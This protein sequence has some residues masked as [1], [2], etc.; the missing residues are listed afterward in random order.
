MNFDAFVNDIKINEWNVF[1]TEVYEDGV[2]THSW[3]DT[4]EN[5]HEIYSATKVVLSIAIGIAIDEGK[6]DISRPVLDYLP[7]NKTENLSLE[8]RRIFEKITLQRLMTMSVGDFPFRAEG[9]SYIDFALNTR[10]S[11]P[12]E[13]VFNYNNISAYLAGVAL[14]EALGT[15]LGP[16]IEERILIPL[17][18]DRYEYSRCPEGYFYGASGMKLTVNGLSRIGLLLYNKGVFDGKRILSE[19]YVDEATSVHQ[20]NREGGYGYFIWKYLDGFSVNGKWGQKCYV[21]PAR[22]IMVS[23]L[24]H[25]EA[26]TTMIRT[27]LEK[28][29]LQ[30]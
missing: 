18:I 15:D 12:D 4:E 27:S 19:A 29:I 26:D 5:L 3:G 14:T 9:D 6:F 11:D 21:L 25:I 2:L 22:K 20:M 8:Q 30:I 28:Y 1:G 17:G 7:E 24:A 10:I 13:R 16:F 23:S